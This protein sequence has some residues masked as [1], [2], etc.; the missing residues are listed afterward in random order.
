MKKLFASVALVLAF[1]NGNAQTV[2]VMSYNIRLDVASDGENRWD[3]RKEMLTSQ[4]LGLSPDFMGVQEALPQQL[5]YL[6]ENLKNYGYIGVGRDDGKRAGE[7]SAIFYNASKYKVLK[8]YTFWLSETPDQPSFGWD[9]ACRRVC[10]YGLFENIKTK[11]KIWAFNTHFDHIGNIARVNSAKMILAKI[12]EVNTQNLPFV[13]TGDFNLEDS[14]ESVKLI[15]SE[16]NDSRKAAK[17]I[18]GPEA[19]F[20]DFKVNEAAKI[21]I[22]YVF[23][24]K[25][26][27]EVK[28]YRTIQEVKS[29]RYPSDHFPLYV[30][31]KIKK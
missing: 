4:V 6:D 31:L 23:V 25:Q 13:L 30:E 16:L 18:S 3:N 20:N 10:T 29:N 28:E 27:V 26:G 11:E 24:P 14:S 19:T 2:K 22:D 8:Q 7:F 21:R 5:D 17:K 1:A 15:S 9:A 12:K